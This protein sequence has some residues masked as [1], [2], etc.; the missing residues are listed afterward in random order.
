MANHH[1][2]NRELSCSCE[3]LLLGFMRLHSH[4]L[5]AEFF[6]EI[7]TVF[8][9]FPKYFSEAEEFGGRRH[10]LWNEFSCAIDKTIIRMI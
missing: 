9:S 1:L 7:P 4:F 3:S 2:R 8:C 6:C 5:F 10:I